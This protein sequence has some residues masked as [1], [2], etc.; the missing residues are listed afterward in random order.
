MYSHYGEGLV[1]CTLTMGR[2]WLSVL[3]LWGG[4]GRVYSHYGKG[5][6][7]CTLIM[8]RDWLSVLS[9]WEGTG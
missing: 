2:D 3:S 1:E 4:T 7:E 8:G 5:L 9:L 6:V